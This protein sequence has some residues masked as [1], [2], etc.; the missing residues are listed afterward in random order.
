VL[1]SLRTNDLPLPAQ[2]APFSRICKR[3]AAAC[4]RV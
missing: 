1:S 3:L 4:G 2:H